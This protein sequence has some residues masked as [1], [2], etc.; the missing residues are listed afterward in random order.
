VEPQ[1]RRS[2]AG[3]IAGGWLVARRGLLAA[4]L[5]LAASSSAQAETVLND[6][7]LNLN[8]DTSSACNPAAPGSFPDAVDATGFDLTTNDPPGT[9]NT[10]GSLRITLDAGDDQYV[11]AYLDYD[12]SFAASGS[13]QDVASVHGSL[14]PGVHFALADPAS[15]LFADFAAN[16]LGDTNDVGVGSGPPMLC[17]DVAWAIGIGGIDVS[18]GSQALVVF[19]VDT[20]QP[21]TG[22]YLQQ[23]NLQSDESIFLTVSL[24]GVPS[25]N[26]TALLASALG[27]LLAWRGS[28]RFARVR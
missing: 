5:A 11:L 15:S 18:A 9:P 3:R 1:G 14:P 21:T 2:W 19:T 10:L 20:Q 28:R 27:A 25:P 16:A 17:C 4:V 24:T 12:L 6:W 8:G 23:R 13:F 26:A 22:F 7:C